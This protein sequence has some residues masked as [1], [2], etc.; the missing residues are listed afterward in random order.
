MDLTPEQQGVRT[1]IITGASIWAAIAALVIAVLLF[2]ALTN[3]PD[4][5]RWFVTV[6]G[7]AGAG[8]LIYRWNYNRGVAKAVCRNCGTAFG[9]REIERTETVVGSEQRQKIEAGKPQSKI[10]RG[11]RKVTTWTEE[12][13]EFTAIDE[14]FN[15][16]NRTERKW[17]MTRDLDKK[18]TEV[19]A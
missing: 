3:A 6:I 19:P 14:C 15:C 9:I 17:T 12:K 18:E 13:L 10:D 7:G 11:T 4:I 2:W 1:K 8:F 5:L 16:H